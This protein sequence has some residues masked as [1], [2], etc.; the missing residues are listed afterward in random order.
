[1]EQKSTIIASTGSGGSKMVAEMSPDQR[2]KDGISST[3]QKVDPSYL[4][5]IDEGT[6]RLGNK[7]RVSQRDYNAGFTRIPKNRLYS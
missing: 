5:D 6:P 2:R 3:G 7:P 4:P 1:M